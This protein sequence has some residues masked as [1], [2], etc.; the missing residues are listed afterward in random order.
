MDC[1]TLRGV[2]AEVALRVAHDTRHGADHDDR[3]G[4][5][6]VGLGACLEKGKQD[7]SGEVYRADVGVVGLSPILECLV[8]PELLLHLR[9]LLCIRLGFSTADTSCGD[10][11]IDVLLFLGQFLVHL[12][13]FELFSYIAW[14]QSDDL[15]S[16]LRIMRLDSPLE[17]LLPTTCDIHLSTCS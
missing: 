2:V 6:A 3:R 15:T 9:S 7:D 11:E 14:A 13:K 5:V 17:S 10:E 8:V 12:L 4:E 1:A 16:F